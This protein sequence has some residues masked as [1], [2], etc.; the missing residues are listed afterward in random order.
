MAKAMSKTNAMRI[1][2]E[3]I[4]YRSNTPILTTMEPLTVSRSQKMGQDPGQ[5]FKTSSRA[6]PMAVSMSL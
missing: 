5:V 6:A 3:K 2:S 4:P 1:W